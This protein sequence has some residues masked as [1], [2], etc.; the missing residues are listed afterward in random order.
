VHHD[1]PAVAD[2]DSGRLLAAV[3]EGVQPVV[4]E[5][6]DIFSGSPNAKDS[7]GISRRTVM[8][9]EIVRKTPVWLSHN[10]SLFALLTCAYP[11]PLE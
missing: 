11:K 5:L 8:R 4:G 7:T 3:L 9:V 1:P 2:G 6:G 10:L